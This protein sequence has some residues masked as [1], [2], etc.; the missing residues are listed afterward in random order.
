M[1]LRQAIFNEGQRTVP[2]F[3]SYKIGAYSG[4]THSPAQDRARHSVWRV[5]RTLDLHRYQN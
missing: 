5:R 1:P 2:R 4:A 3:L